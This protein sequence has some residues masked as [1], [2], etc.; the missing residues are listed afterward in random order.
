VTVPCYSG[1]TETEGVGVCIAGNFICN[2]GVLGTVCIGEITPT[3]DTCDGLDN[4]CNGT[5]DDNDPDGDGTSDCLD[6]CPSD[7]TKTEPGICGCGTPDEDL[8]ADNVIDCNDNCPSDPNPDQLDVDEDGIGD[9]CD[10]D[11]GDITGPA[12]GPG[13]DPEI[14]GIQGG[15]FLSCNL[16]TEIKSAGFINPRFSVA[17]MF[18]FVIGI[19]GLRRTWVTRSNT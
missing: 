18:F 15:G 17:W 3:L 5:P 6:D 10:D 1:P 16:L 11:E 19:L 14:M 4:D 8:D 12:G 7:E 2:G 13:E 9:E